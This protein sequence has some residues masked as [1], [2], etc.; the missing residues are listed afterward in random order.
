MS[1]Y[2]GFISPLMPLATTVQQTQTTIT[3]ALIA[4]GWQCRRQALVPA[5]IMPTS[6]MVGYA[7]SLDNDP[8]TQAGTTGVT[9]AWVGIIMSAV[10]TPVN[11]YIKC[12]S[13]SI[14]TY[15]VDAP[16][17]FSLDYWTGAAWST[18]QTWVAQNNWVG[19]EMRKF[20]VTGATAQF[21]WRLNV[22]TSTGPNMYVVEWAL[23]DASSPA[24]WAVNYYFADF[25]PPVTETI[26]NSNARDV[27][28]F[29]YANNGGSMSIIGVQELL[30][31]L[32][33]VWN[34]DTFT[35]GAV[36]SSL[37]IGTTVSYTGAGGNTST[38][39]AR[40]LY[41][42][43]KASADANFTPYN[44]FWPV[45]GQKSSG[46]GIFFSLKV[47]A[48]NLSSLPISV[49]STLH[50]RGGYC[51]PIVQCGSF[52]RADLTTLTIDLT[53]GFVYYIQICSRGL[54][55][56]IKTNVGYYGAVHACYTDNASALAQLPVSDIP[57]VLCTPIELIVGVDGL[58]TS[59]SS[60]GYIPRM[61]ALGAG[62]FAPIG[63]V[64]PDYSTFIGSYFNKF[65][66]SQNVQD[67]A[68]NSINAINGN[69]SSPITLN[70][71]GISTG[72]NS[73]VFSV[74][75][76]NKMIGFPTAFIGGYFANGYNF[77]STYF[78]PSFPNIDWYK[79]IG[80]SAPAS[81]QLVL[82]PSTDFIAVVNGNQT[83]AAT[84]INVT[85]AS[86]VVFP[87]GSPGYIIIDGE[88]ITYTGLINAGT[89]GATSSFTGCTR[90]VYGIPALGLPDQTPVQIGAW[91][92][93]INSSLLFAG[94]QKPT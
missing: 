10:F 88:P 22:L 64:T 91:F 21:Q 32:P 53:N 4:Y 12:A 60:I 67:C 31:A 27:V 36:T 89:G 50:C 20:T 77:G 54:G 45:A 40:G 80:A 58:V 65:C 28:R 52:M 92:C 35:T 9:A 2:L 81:E 57:G 56:G 62:N 14:Q 94:Y 73:Y 49:N 17:S 23:E 26:G 41:E 71:E 82:S 43:L 1:T 66:A 39:N 7:N 78:S 44:W 8:T 83:S 16:L 15:E 61:W 74:F 70:A 3:S 68:Q 87:A 59:T 34:L 24:N 47:P 86:G 29:L 90:G 33:Q 19:G 76:I 13:T 46:G 42:A 84:T 38:Q 63:T 85:C 5:T 11:M 75:P 69:F 37:T 18:V 93:V 55:V 25:I 48:A 6:T 30:T 72:V 79:Y 51:P